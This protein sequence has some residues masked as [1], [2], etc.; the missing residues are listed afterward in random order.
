MVVHGY[1]TGFQEEKTASC[2]I[3]DCKT[4]GYGAGFNETNKNK[5]E[6]IQQLSLAPK[7]RS[8]QSITFYKARYSPEF[9]K[10]Y[11]KDGIQFSYS[12]N[13]RKN[14]DDL[15]SLLSSPPYFYLKS[16]IT[17]QWTCYAHNL[18][19]IIRILSPFVNHFYHLTIITKENI[20]YTYYILILI[21]VYTQYI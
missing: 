8:R 3:G 13:A 7:R 2:G 20:S 12:N 11:H 10:L 16:G 14:R 18:P 6:L 17:Y 4:S 1:W 9:S 21:Y 19:H 5:M 15:Y